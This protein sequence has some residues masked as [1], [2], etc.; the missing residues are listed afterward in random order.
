MVVGNEI[1]LQYNYFQTKEV[2]EKNFKDKAEA[3]GAT[4]A[5]HDIPQMPLAGQKYTPQTV[6]EVLVIICQC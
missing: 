5:P 6:V 4:A 2:L 3:L 1:N